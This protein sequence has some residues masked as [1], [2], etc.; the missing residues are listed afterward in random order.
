MRKIIALGVENVTIKRSMLH[1]DVTMV[2]LVEYEGKLCLGHQDYPD[3]DDPDYKEGWTIH[4]LGSKERFFAK[5]FTSLWV[6]YYWWK[7]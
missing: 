4:E 3:E 5:N 6:R 7:K 2:A 1:Y